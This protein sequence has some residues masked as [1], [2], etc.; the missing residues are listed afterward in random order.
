MLAFLFL[1]FKLCRIISQYIYIPNCLCGSVAKASDTQSVGN[2][3][4]PR[5]DH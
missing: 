1:Y 4:E 5:P 2:G 3:F